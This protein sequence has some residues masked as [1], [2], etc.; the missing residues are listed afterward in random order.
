MSEVAEEV[1]LLAVHPRRQLADD[2]ADGAADQ[3]EALLDDAVP[4]GLVAGGRVLG[5][6]QRVAL[7]GIE[8]DQEL[9]RPCLGGALSH[10]RIA[11]DPG[12]SPDAVI[13]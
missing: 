11:A 10:R 7:V 9:L 4:Y 8:P 2:A 3:A 13:R 6:P 12:V 1:Q 5:R